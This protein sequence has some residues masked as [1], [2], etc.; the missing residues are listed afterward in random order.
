MT[1]LGHRTANMDAP[2]RRDDP[3]DLQREFHMAQQIPR[4]LLPGPLPAGAPDPNTADAPAVLVRIRSRFA[5][6]VPEGKSEK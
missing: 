2:L 5:K 3:K 6:L 1:L 4:R